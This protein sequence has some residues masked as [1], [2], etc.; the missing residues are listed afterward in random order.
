MKAGTSTKPPAPGVSTSKEKQKLPPHRKAIQEATKLNP[1][2]EMST[3]Q[4][5]TSN[6]GLPLSQAEITEDYEAA[7]VNKSKK[8]QYDADVR[9]VLDLD[10]WG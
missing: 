5:T 2:S 10:K 1:Q 6:P 8:H 3:S 7:K 9:A 4:A